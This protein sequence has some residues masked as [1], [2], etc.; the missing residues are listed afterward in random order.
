MNT[1]QV[2][3]FISQGDEKL[4][5]VE[6]IV[7]RKISPSFDKVKSFNLLLSLQEVEKLIHDRY[8]DKWLLF[9][10]AQWVQLRREDKLVG[11]SKWS[12][13]DCIKKN[14]IKRNNFI[15]IRVS[16]R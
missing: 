7:N 3:K 8:K 9:Q 10:L 11:I 12:V 15:M 16:K 4:E 2:I 13:H 14:S 6:V 1:I 5:V